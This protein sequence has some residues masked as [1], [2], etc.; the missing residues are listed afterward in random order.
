M[1]SRR[2]GG[3]YQTGHI[4]SRNM[5]PST[6]VPYP[7]VRRTG[8][9]LRLLASK[10]G[11]SGVTL[12]GSKWKSYYFSAWRWLP[13][14]VL[15][16]LWSYIGFHMQTRWVGW[17][18][19]SEEMV[20]L[21]TI[22]DQSSRTSLTS[23][24]SSSSSLDS[25]NSEAVANEDLSGVVVGAG[26]EEKLSFK[27]WLFNWISW[28]RRQQLLNQ[29]IVAKPKKA[30]AVAG[31][32]GGT[33]GNMQGEVLLQKHNSS[34]GGRLVGPFDGIIERQ[35]PGLLPRRRS[36]MCKREGLFPEFVKG[37]NIIVVFHE[38]SMTGAPLAM[39]ELA[40][41][42]VR[43]GGKVSAVVLNKKGGLYKE[44]LSRGVF[45]LRDKFSFSWKTAAKADLVIAGSAACN[46]WIG[47]YLHFNKKGSE[48]LIWWVMENRR[49]YF[50]RAKLLLGKA[51][52]LVFLSET[53]EQLWRNWASQEALSLP[54][55]FVHHFWAIGN[56]EDKESLK[57][58]R[59]RLDLRN[60][61]RREM[62]LDST[63]FLVVALS[64]INPGKGQLMLIQAA[65]MVEEG[66]EDE[67]LEGL[68]ILLGSVGSKSNKPAY[69]ERIYGLLDRH[70]RLANMVLWTPATVHVSPLYAAADAYVMNA[71]GIGETFGRV[72]IEAMAFGLPVLGTDA[73]GTKEILESN[74][75][76]VLHPVGK[77]GIPV[78][79]RHLR[80]LLDHPDLGIQM[81]ERGRERVSK[82]FREGPMYDKLARI[83]IDCVREQGG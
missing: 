17:E 49:E 58:E 26:H 35:A 36:R 70:P 2:T 72:T 11:R 23:T 61:V 6:S 76:G 69:L 21:E 33:L 8:S 62:G 45:V 1:P 46:T 50:D 44:L 22:N 4:P 73:G 52:A 59:N 42:M 13:W 57:A 25:N 54:S 39:L 37:K 24:A 7:S 66:I 14:L 12:L 18:L 15:I 34:R 31:E 38:L 43:C 20:K 47:Q 83:F 30:V 55:I 40:S 82:M 53:Q 32:D 78:L 41:E 63:D 29:Q 5:G 48:R 71:Q 56:K 67:G 81:G 51:R 16:C 60:K 65:L 64:S 28:R 79:A 75:T 9:S 27:T 68:K 77:V 19:E 80:W 74:V 10:E 3:T